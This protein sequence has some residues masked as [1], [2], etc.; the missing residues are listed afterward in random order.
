MRLPAGYLVDL[1]WN[2]TNVHRSSLVSEGAQT[3]LSVL[4][5]STSEESANVIYESRMLRAAVDLLYIGPVVVL[6]IDQS[7]TKDDSHATG[8]SVSA[9]TLSIVIVSPA[10]D[11][12]R[13]AEHHRV[14]IST[15]DVHWTLVQQHFDRN[16]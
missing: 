3:Q 6:E 8:A 16:R 15:F 13:S 2:L 5:S 10:V 11:V 14:H 7:W 4:A 1:V 12:S 9:S